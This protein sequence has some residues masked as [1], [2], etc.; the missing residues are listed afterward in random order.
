MLVNDSSGCKTGRGPPSVGHNGVYG[1]VKKGDE[2]GRRRQRQN[3]HRQQRPRRALWA[4]S[5]LAYQDRED[6]DLGM[7]EKLQLCGRF[8][9]ENPPGWR[10]STYLFP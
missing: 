4:A 10:Q 8:T 3:Q 7:R 6:R 5:A 2:T 9:E 1:T